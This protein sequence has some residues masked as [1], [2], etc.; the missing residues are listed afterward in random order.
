MRWKIPLTLIQISGEDSL[1]ISEATLSSES[2]ENTIAFHSH[3]VDGW[4]KNGSALLDAVNDSPCL[5]FVQETGLTQPSQISSAKL[6]QAQGYDSCWGQPA[7]IKANSSGRFRVDK[8]TTPGV[9]VIWS[10]TLAVSPIQPRT[11]GGK[12][13]Y[14]LGR[15]VSVWAKIGGSGTLCR[16]VYGPA[17]SRAQHERHQ[18][19]QDVLQE[20]FAWADTPQM[21]IGD[22]NESLPASLLAGELIPKGWR[23]P[24]HGGRTPKVTYR[25][26]N[27]LSWL[28]SAFLSPEID[29]TCQYLKI[30][31]PFSLSACYLDGAG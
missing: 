3:N 22:F 14:G 31:W 5:L 20:L 19:Q 8:G 18:H 21:V 17:G 6:L 12:R 4:R 29:I 9:G 13:Q 16:N 7:Q 27:T 25:S 1:W 15:L 2:V 10:R 23:I 11:E 26:G 28:D 30:W 24:I